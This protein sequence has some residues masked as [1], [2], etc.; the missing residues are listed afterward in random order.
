MSLRTHSKDMDLSYVCTAFGGGGHK[1][2]SAF[3]KEKSFFDSIIIKPI[4][5]YKDLQKYI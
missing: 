5:L 4:D 3:A 1:T 2:A